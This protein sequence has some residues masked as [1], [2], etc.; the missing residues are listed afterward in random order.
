MP[1][2]PP[3]ILFFF[4][5]QHRADW[6]GVNPKLPLKTPNLDRLA[7]SG[8]RFS[9]AFCPS[10]LCAPS[11]A[12]LASG[13]SYDRCGVVNN[14]QDYPLDQPTCYQAL[15][16]AG[17]RVAGVG[18][19]D[20]HK[21]TSDP[22][23][24]TWH[25]D[26]SRLLKEW[27]F[28]DG[29]DNEG[30]L[31][32]SNSYRTTGEPKGP[33]LA[34][35]QKRE[36]VDVYIKEHTERGKHMD[37]YTTALPDDAYCDNWVSENGL[38]ILNSFPGD[39]PWHLVINFTGPHN[40]MDVTESMRKRWEDVDFPLPHNND[41]PDSEGLLRNRQNYAAMIENIDRQV[42]RFI[43]CVKERGELDNT[44][45]IY[46]SDHGEMLG[47]QGRWSKSIWFHPATNIPLIVSGPGIQRGVVSEALVSLHDL[48]AT[49]IEYTGARPMPD[50]DSLGLK[51]LLEGKRTAH[52]DHIV[53][54]LDDWRMVF[55]GRYKLVVQ[56]GHEPILFDMGEDPQE[57]NNIAKLRPNVVER[58][59]PL[60]KIE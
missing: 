16:D 8:V 2:R 52:R 42:G 33:Y 57:D 32:G 27:G 13:K 7:D 21:D 56:K 45:I 49:I 17:Y 22:A 37:A 15:R 12:C 58:L 46:A 55:D 11:R 24:L 34:F 6:L 50:M 29:I 25:L 41:H 38:G 23:N 60:I 19:F 44:L 5:D 35:L 40:P 36:L 47:D 53:S 3:N 30:K 54:G 48:T 10:P 39:Q 31:D 26:G 20:M 59:R 28:T 1:K 9:R 14:N 4:P 43:D 51:D 18:K